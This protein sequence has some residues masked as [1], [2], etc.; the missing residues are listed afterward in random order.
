MDKLLQLRNANG[1]RCH[2]A[3]Q[4]TKNNLGQPK[5]TTAYEPITGH[6]FE[7]CF[8]LEIWD[9]IGTVLG[10]LQATNRAK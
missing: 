2:S 10:Q 1:V 7:A 6:A 4:A 9:S 8:L 5:I 3:P